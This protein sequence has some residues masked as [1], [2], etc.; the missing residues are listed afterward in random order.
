MKSKVSLSWKLLFTISALISTI[1]FAQFVELKT[2]K[3]EPIKGA[4][5][6]S[7]QNP[8]GVISNDQGQIN[9]EEFGPKETLYIKHI[10][11]FSLKITKAELLKKGSI[12]M[13]EKAK[14]LPPIYF[15]HPLRYT[16]AKDDEAGQI[17]DISRDIVKIE[18]PPTSADMLQNTGTILVQKSQGGGG[19]PII[20]GFEANKLL[21]VI[22]GVR[23]NNAIYRSGHL[24]NSITVDNSIL[25]R[26]EVIF[27]PSSALFGSD[28]LG[29]VIHFQTRDPR[30]TLEDSAYFEGGS[31]VRLNSNNRTMT[32]HFHFSTGKNRWALLSSITASKFGDI[33]MG[34]NRS[35]HNYN[36]WGLHPNIVLPSAAGDTM[37]ANTN[38]HLQ[39]GTGYTQ[40]DILEKF[41]FQANDRLKYT[42]NFQFSNSSTID[43]YDKLTEYRNG[44]LRYAE[45]YYGPQTRL[46]GQFKLDFNKGKDVNKKRIYNTG[47]LSIAYQRIDEDRISRRFQNDW[48]LNQEED[49][50]IFSVN[51]DMNKVFTGSR[52]LFYGFEAQHNVVR[53]VAFSENIQSNERQ[54]EQTRYPDFSNY[55][56]SGIYV[57]YKQKF[58]N[59]TS[60]TAGLRY[61][62]IYANSEFRDTSFISLPFNQVNILTSAPSG[63]VGFVFR[64]DTLTNIRTQITSGF[65]APN[66]DDYGK[67][68]QKAD[69]TVVPNDN[70]TPEYALGGELTLERSFG[71]D[72]LKI[73]ATGY[74]TY[75][76]NAMVQR[77]FNLNGQDSI[78]YEGE[79]T[80]IQAIV[81]TDNAL[82]Y[83]ASTF[84]LVNIAKGLTFNYTYNYT[85][86]IDL[87]N[88]TPLEHIPPQFGKIAFNYVG[89]KL[90]TSLFTFY[91]FRKPI[92][93]YT[94]GGDNIDLTPNEQ[95][96]PPW[97][98]LNY[99]ISYTFFNSVMVQF[100]AENILDFHYRQFASGLSAPGRNFMVSIKADF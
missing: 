31:Y 48:R 97:W 96:I 52:A 59:N 89:K 95:G 20:R 44:V 100:A 83:G 39:V 77:D 30:I 70:L 66:I 16:V 78:V 99:R 7:T 23:M 65:R 36:D 50:N 64:P 53:S 85:K 8:N 75:L 13:T 9:L 74:G 21:L 63:N 57:Q 4:F 98:T 51:L 19:S 62:V 34:K 37:I 60:F 11:F 84:L 29:G 82:V 38:Q 42:F 1:T 93:E 12:T 3:G 35:L 14:S 27:G 2:V 33:I 61:S 40:Y 80:K 25:E 72:V 79:T 92:D 88:D 10:Q 67:V 24:Q 43:R 90:N 56:T 86:G 17:E 71:R 81:N 45:W 87:G 54:A 55:L 49:L 76:F 5:V 41:V 15:D 28:A 32:G 68:F 6:Y 73:G 26:T 18:N 69:Y 46:L 22:D 94:E 58:K 91:N 47:A